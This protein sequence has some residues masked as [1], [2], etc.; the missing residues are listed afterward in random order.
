MANL[1]TTYVG[2]KLKS[3]IIIASSG[4]TERVELLKKCED[5]GA[6]AAVMKSYFEEAVCRHSPSPR[7]RVI[8]HDM[9]KE[10]TFTFMSYEQASEWA[11]E[12]YAQ[13]VADA[14]AQLKHLKIIPSINCLTKEGWVNSAKLLEEAGADAIEMNTSCPHGSITFRGGAVEKTICDM[15]KPVREAISIPLV[16][17]ISPMLTS[18][19]ALVKALEEIGVDGVTIFNRM[20]ALEID[21]DAEKP[22]MHEG[23]MGHGGPWAMLYPLRWISQIKPEVKIDISGSG[24]VMTWEDVVK[25]ILTGATAVQTCTAVMLNG[26]EII[27]DFLDGLAEYMDRKGYKRLEDFRGNV[28]PKILGT[29]EVDRR[30]KV[31]ASIDRSLAAPC[32]AACPAGVPAQS[33]VRLIA[34]RKFDEALTMIRSKNPF[35]SICGRVCYHPCETACTRGDL[36]DPI[37]VRAL[38]RFACEWGRKNRPLAKEPIERA[39]D[40][41]R[42]VAVIGA[43]PAG[44]SAA[45][46]LAKMGHGVTVF[47]GSS[48]AGGMLRWGIPPYRLPRELL[49]EEIDYI[50]RA[51]VDIRLNKRLGKDFTLDDLRNNGFDA[52]LIAIGAWRSA[53]LGI[54]GEKSQGVV[55]ALD[56][57]A[58]VNVGGKVDVPARVVVVGGGNS[59]IDSARCALRLGAKEVYLVYRR[60]RDEMPAS[61][62]EIDDAEAEGVRILYLATPVKVVKKKGKVAG[63]MCRGGCL[64]KAGRDGRRSPVPIADVEYVL[65]ADMIITAVSQAPDSSCLSSKKK[66]RVGRSGAVTVN[67]VTGATNLKGV[68]AAGDAAGRPGSVIEAIGHGKRVA[69]HINRTLNGTAGADDEAAIPELRPAD[70]RSVVRRCIEYPPAARVE[71]SKLSVSR[72]TSGFREI[73]KTLTE[74]EAVREASRCLACG[75]GVGCGLCHR[76]C[77]HDAIEQTEDGYRVDDQKCQGCALCEQRCPNDNITMAPIEDPDPVPKE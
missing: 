17:K 3:P 7:Y 76:I 42:R 10:K 14:K 45:F 5:N 73:E 51:G 32:K 6:G 50:R 27:R 19:L 39:P 65:P 30:K 60:T 47:E 9:G 11:I 70:K 43:G 62:E 53:E 24:G 15:V 29:E 28:T 26:Y 64:G 68:F 52:V 40:T 44:L 13:E 36:D 61:D 74:E 58:P 75:C 23:Y 16:A 35:Q 1:E 67:E 12:R 41:G 25:Y 31:Y 46:D 49:D 21:I 20:T 59:A 55:A 66:L 72:R 57:L 56:F 37:A 4:I 8:H 48:A 63:L 22:I 71:A 54:P 2:L 18:P 34:E 33:Y 38:K 69:V 77:L